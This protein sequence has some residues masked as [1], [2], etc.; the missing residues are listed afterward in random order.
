M[1]DAQHGHDMELQNL[2]AVVGR[3]EAE[4]AEIRSETEQQQQERA[5]LLAQVI[6][7]L[8]CDP[9]HYQQ[10]TLTFAL[11]TDDPLLQLLQKAQQAA[12]RHVTH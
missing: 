3:L 1:H 7:N 2:G 9:K 6:E 4:L 11:R 10:R 8:E 5:H 12:L